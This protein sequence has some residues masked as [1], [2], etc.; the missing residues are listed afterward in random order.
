MQQ[1]N[2]EISRD[3]Y[4]EQDAQSEL[5]L[6]FHDGRILAIADAGRPDSCFS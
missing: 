2:I 1:A 6:E 5:K 4:L 3:D